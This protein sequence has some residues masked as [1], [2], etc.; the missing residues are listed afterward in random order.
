[1][2]L[3][4]GKYCIYSGDVNQ[5]GIIDSGDLRLIDNDYSSYLTGYLV[6]DLN[7]DNIV[8]SG[9]LAIADNN[10]SG[11][12]T[13]IVPLPVTPP[14]VLSITGTLT[15]FAQTSATPSAEQTYNISGTN[16]TANVTLVPPAGFE[17]SKTTG[18]GFVSSTGSLVFTAADVMA[19]QTIYVRLNAGSPGSYSGNITHTSSNSEFTQATKS[20]S[21]SYNITPVFTVT[22]TLS[23]FSQTSSTPSAEQTY[24]ISGT[25]LTANV[26]VVPPA[27][28]EISKTT[29]T[30]FVN[31]T[32]SLVYTAANVMAGQ[33][34]Y[35]RMNAG[36]T[37]SYSGN[38]THTSAGS[39]FTQVTLPVSGLYSIL[40][41]NVNLIMGY[42][43]AATTDINNPHAFLL[44]KDVFCASYDR[45]RGIPNWTSWQLNSTWCNGPGVRQDNY[46]PDPS[47][48]SAWYHVSGTDY[49]GSGFSRGHMC[50]SADRI[51]TQADNDSLFYYTNMVPQNQDN[52]AGDWEGLENYE[53]TLANAG[54]TL[55]I[56]SGG[57][58]SGGKVQASTGDTTT[59][60][61]I[62]GGK[63]T[64]PSKLWKVIIV[65]PNG[66]GTSGDV[67]K[68][69]TST[70]TIAM[71]IPNDSTPNNMNTWGNYRV[72]VAS[73]ES[74]T[75]FTFFSNVPSSIN[76]LIKANV[77]TG[78]TN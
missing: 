8:D 24:N 78:P 15:S 41:S 5:D 69:T 60:Y 45:D 64:V 29:G 61:T 40:S 50:P 33:T 48:P 35:V 66:D 70:R 65:V 19:G 63:V 74:L 32:G 58:G 11:Y 38:I 39:E 75:G 52:N 12:I 46:I 37:G 27:G 23:A 20:V 51:N 55:Y 76:S 3:K 13:S 43:A 49:T 44:A 56:V 18:T 62:S 54:N 17:I 21:G 47:L 42:P 28:F 4:D 68:V 31:S 77:D 71:L 53:R 73:I 14:A 6:T 26:T 36:S 2:G 16:I 22:S 1:M 67:S 10:Y 57:Y 72:S 9:D 25:S 30:G 59:H 7:G 34:I